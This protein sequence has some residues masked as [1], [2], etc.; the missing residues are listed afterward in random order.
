MPIFSSLLKR[1]FLGSGLQGLLTGILGC[2]WDCS[3]VRLP[4]CYGGRQ[5]GMHGAAL[6]LEMAQSEHFNA[7]VMKYWAIVVL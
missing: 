4:R 7:S 3:A 1:E 5:R 2:L 6:V